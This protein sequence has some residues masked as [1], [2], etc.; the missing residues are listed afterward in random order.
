MTL[1]DSH[2]PDQSLET[3]EIWFGLTADFHDDQLSEAFHT[4]LNDHERARNERYR[5]QRDRQ[6]HLLARLMC[7]TILS[8]YQPDVLPHQWQFQPG[9][10]GKPEVVGPKCN[11]GQLHFNLSHTE[12][13]VVLAV[14]RA[15]AIGVDVECT[16]R[17][18]DHLGLA[19]RY[20]AQVEA[21]AVKN[22]L[23]EDR[24]ALFYRIWTLK[25]AYVK[26]VGQ[27]LAHALDSFWFE[28]LNTQDP[29]PQLHIR[30]AIAPASW[31]AQVA[32]LE[33]VEPWVV[34]VVAHSSDSRIN[35]TR[36]PLHRFQINGRLKPLGPGFEHPPAEA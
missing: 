21:E 12:G 6:L 9:P 7:R 3:P 8:R 28:P 20:F 1:P 2:A 15:G 33:T 29:N 11:Q 23:A 34:A 36:W 5:H 31:S 35:S 17:P 32:H 10:H 18:I 25:E 22:R 19:N 14:S 13:V 30:D 24:G 27:G 26:A 4:I 16:D